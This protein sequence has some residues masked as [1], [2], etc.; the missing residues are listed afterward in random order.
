[1]NTENR[2]SHNY[3][4]HNLTF[5][6]NNS[7]AQPIIFE[8]GW[9]Y[10]F[11]MD[12]YSLLQERNLDQSRDGYMT[13]VGTDRGVRSAVI[14]KT[15]GIYTE[16]KT[17]KRT[18]GLFHTAPS[19]SD[20]S[21][22]TPF[23]GI[24]QVYITDYLIKKD[25]YDNKG[26][27][28]YLQAYEKKIEEYLEP[29]LKDNGKYQIFR[30]ITA[31]DFCVIIRTS[32]IRNIYEAALSIMS[33]KNKQNKRIFFTYSNIGIE[34]VKL[35]KGPHSGTFFGKLKKSV[36]NQNCDVMFAL[37]FRIE[38]E[39]LE[40]VQSLTNL[41]N[42]EDKN[43]RQLVVE[44]V[45]GMVGRYDLVVRFRIDEFMEIYPFLCMNITGCEIE[46]VDP[47]SFQNQLVGL[48]VSKMRQGIIQTINTRVMMDIYTR[49]TK[50]ETDVV[51]LLD[52]K[53]IKE[54]DRKN[55]HVASLYEKFEKQYGTKLLTE[56]YRYEE[57]NHMLYNLMNSYKN[58]AYEIDTH[59]NWF[60]C[61]Q[62]LED[63][64]ANMESFMAHV[65]DN[66]P[67][68]TEKFLNDF[69]IFIS[70]FDSYLRLS[71][72]MNQS[73]I[74]APRYDITTPIDGQKFLIAYNEFID[75]IHEAYCKDDRDAKGS[76]VCREERR[77]E[78]TIIYPDVT[79]KNLQLMEVFG[80]DTVTK[81][82]E[83]GKEKLIPA[84]LICKIPMFEYFERPYDLIPLASHEICHHML[85][86][87]RKIRNEFLIKIIFDQIAI[88]A[89]KEVQIRFVKDKYAVK[90]DALMHVLGKAL[91]SVLAS[92]Y[93]EQDA[94]WENYVFWH[95][96]K[97]I[98]NYV[99]FYFESEEKKQNNLFDI[100]SINKVKT[101]FEELIREVYLDNVE[102]S[103]KNFRELDLNANDPSD[104][105]QAQQ[106]LK[107]L[108]GKILIQINTITIK[109]S[110]P[111]T[112]KELSGN[113]NK[114]LD[115]FLLTWIENN[116]K[117]RETKTEIQEL[118]QAKYYLELVKR[119]YILYREAIAVGEALY[120]ERGETLAH[121]FAKRAKEGYKK[122]LYGNEYYIYDKEMHKKATFWEFADEMRSKEHFL[123]AMESINPQ[124]LI[125]TIDFKVK[126][127]REICAD[128]IMCRW[129]GFSSFG[130][131]RMSVTLG[132]RMQGYTEQIQFGRPYRE[133]LVIG[134]AVLM[135]QEYK[136]N[137][138]RVKNSADDWI[139]IDLAPLKKKIWD[140]LDAAIR[141]TK[142]RI[143][144][145]VFKDI[146]KGRKDEATVNKILIAFFDMYENSVDL[147]KGYVQSGKKIRWKNSIWD[148][149]CTGRLELFK[150][151]PE[152][153]GYFQKEVN[154][155]KRMYEILDAYQQIQQN[156]KLK[157][158]T[159]IL[160][161]A[162]EIY[163]N[164]NQGESLHCVVNEVVSFYNDPMSEKK[165]NA[166]KM[167]DMLCFVQDYYY[168]NRIKKAEANADGHLVC[169]KFE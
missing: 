73:I 6:R 74:Q 157:I 52:R 56:K 2:N 60:I 117:P 11:M 65:E 144:E 18:E 84:I 93:K 95:L 46:M 131:F 160:R 162:S 91:S 92:D 122:F 100:C 26:V 112:V 103:I 141:Y 105:Y 15:M 154:S 50:E 31:E 156:N 114:E 62:Y 138:K 28:E 32:K 99:Q 9:N 143:K 71:Q 88:E 29:V 57:L 79:I 136:D 94:E 10:F 41:Q 137:S 54:I 85:I 128:I 97:E 107:K 161:H 72:G 80:Y 27:D 63:L 14:K 66:A 78:N 121:K 81:R 127:Y 12:Y 7:Y 51:P 129:L 4:I 40:E 44:A 61:S 145:A 126:I 130:Y 151:R 133:R 69:Q 142:S 34:C 146:Q 139:E 53:R 152:F 19:K 64:F 166:E 150:D 67:M 167:V 33:I 148:Q 76:M 3:D 13:L 23:L 111:I 24:I 163:I 55:E 5:V 101:E 134:L 83:G 158:E 47:A 70:A 106:N 89:I 82:K 124:K 109:C 102:E 1:M 116:L 169:Q 115:Y 98:K 16:K 45:N 165:T 96:V 37:R 110:N 43:S 21:T 75:E 42:Y 39:A 68:A 168:C 20:A 108:V 48:I 22:S 77:P 155:F 113:S 123:E 159:S 25:D 87:D 147:L 135:E 58:L 36:R 104:K 86:L 119:T 140:Y 118:Q 30:T 153:K 38:K 35:N 164:M 8:T 132:P 90:D 120:K 125:D 149:L 49:E 59:I 17:Q